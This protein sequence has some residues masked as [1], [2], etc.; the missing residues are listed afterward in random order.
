MS[1]KWIVKSNN[2]FSLEN[3]SRS[4]LDKYSPFMLQ[5]LSDRGITEEK[6]IQSFFDFDYEGDVLDPFK[7]KGMEEAVTRLILAREKKERIAIFGDYDA[8][9]VTALSLLMEVFEELGFSD[10]L[11]YVPDRQNEGYGLNEGAIDFLKEQGAELIV[12]VD[13]GVSNADEIASAKKKGIDLIITDH[14]NVPDNLPKDVPI[15]NPHQKD[16]PYGF[17]DL[18]GVGVAFK[19]AQALYKKIDPERIDQLK[20]YLDLVAIGTIADCVPLLRENRALVKF[21]LIVLSKTRRVGLREMF[22][23][24][25]IAISDNKKADAEKVAFQ[26]S[27]RLNAAGRMDHANVSC[28]LILE[29]DVVSA[30]EMA[31]DVEAKN[32]ER[33]KVTAEIVR[34]IR[35]IAE[36]SFK[37]KKFIFVSNPHWPVGILGLVAGRI[38]EEFQKP[39]AVFQDQGE[40]LVGSF[41]SVPDFNVIEA[42]KSNSGFLLKFG[43]HSQAAGVSIKKEN[44]EKFYQSMGNLCEKALLE[45][46]GQTILEI[47]LEITPED[48]DFQFVSELGRMEPFGEANREP[49][50]LM[51]N[52][53]IESIRTVGNG[54]KHLKISLRG[55][56]GSPK[57]FDAIG[58]SLGNKFPDL[59]QGDKIDIV[60]NLSEDEWNGS[61]KIQLKIIDL[62]LSKTNEQG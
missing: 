14:H 60:F 6:D 10:L 16:C 2:N 17:K 33:Q 4:V 52:M 35:I 58:F 62:N 3:F 46:D 53:L 56:T 25:R 21:G 30:R 49:I 55:E 54:N 34:E 36:N 22:K 32:Q 23:V 50:F 15:I 20:W 29:K 31:L 13:C 42:I 19:L 8:D 48:I 59:K 18:A 26:I 9:G 1:K 47:D 51:R 24:G 37:D 7:L 43:G 11:Y 38:C 45:K 61:K 44:L 5:L 12:T 41:R 39:T 57:I 28:K 27:P 40:E